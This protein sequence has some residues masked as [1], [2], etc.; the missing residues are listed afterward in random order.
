MLPILNCIACVEILR[1]NKGF[2]W[3]L[4]Q[5]PS[6][7]AWSY[8]AAAQSG[9]AGLQSIEGSVKAMHKKMKVGILVV[10]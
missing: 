9:D 5:F 1:L 4:L 10:V 3:S 7:A 8:L 6:A 2:L